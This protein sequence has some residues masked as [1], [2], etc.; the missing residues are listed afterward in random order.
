LFFREFLNIKKNME[1]D[2]S[3]GLGG[4]DQDDS[5]FGTFLNITGLIATSN[6]LEAMAYTNGLSYGLADEPPV[7]QNKNIPQH[8]VL[9]P[10]QA[11]VKKI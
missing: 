1:T 10:N 9:T 6:P 11:V 8:A 4:S 3:R 5:L 7:T 2:E